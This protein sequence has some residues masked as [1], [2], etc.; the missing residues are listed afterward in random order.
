MSRMSLP[1]VAEVL[2][3]CA[4]LANGNNWQ[5][6][7]HFSRSFHPGQPRG[8]RW[9][10]AQLQQQ[11][12]KAALQLWQDIVETLR[13]KA[14][15]PAR[16]RHAT[17]QKFYSIFLNEES[18]I[19]AALHRF[20]AELP[21]GYGHAAAK[22]VHQEVVNVAATEANRSS[23]EPSMTL[24]FSFCGRAVSLSSVKAS[25]TIKRLKQELHDQGKLS[26]SEWSLVQVILNGKAI[27]DATVLNTLLLD[28]ATTIHLIRGSFTH[29][30]EVAASSRSVQQTMRR[31]FTRAQAETM[32]ASSAD[33]SD[34]QRN[35]PGLSD[36]EYSAQQRHIYKKYQDRIKLAGFR[37]GVVGYMKAAGLRQD[38]IT[39]TDVCRDK[40]K[41]IIRFKLTPYGDKEHRYIV[42]QS[43]IDQLYHGCA[44]G[45][46]KER[47]LANPAE[48][49]EAYLDLL[50][51]AAV[52]DSV[53]CTM[54]RGDALLIHGKSYKVNVIN[55]WL[56]FTK[57]G[58]NPILS[59]NYKVNG[60]QVP[61]R[62]EL[63]LA[64]E[65]GL[66]R[67]MTEQAYQEEVPARGTASAYRKCGVKCKFGLRAI[68]AKLMQHIVAQDRQLDYADAH[69]MSARGRV[70]MAS[71]T[72]LVTARSGAGHGAG[73]GA[74][75]SAG[76]Q[77]DEVTLCVRLL[78]GQQMSMTMTNEKTIADIKRTMI[79]K[80][81]SPDYLKQHYDD[82]MQMKLIYAGCV[83]D[84]ALPVSV[85]DTD[86]TVLNCTIP[87]EYAAHILTADQVHTKSA[88]L[89]R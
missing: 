55:W 68:S 43:S 34:L 79:N 44:S 48:K 77:Q 24:C 41:Y 16:R 28:G 27:A 37:E 67:Y 45:D 26:A 61:R 85:I 4:E 32:A 21:G 54:L 39:V 22:G 58:E 2:S 87:R 81:F 42:D 82:L 18:D 33:L 51:T 3:A 80:Y 76:V 59:I 47:T 60:G 72:R 15:H 29:A 75:V 19:L 40:A 52:K 1:V 11:Q 46:N 63:E 64:D 71:A 6:W 78:T 86:A 36:D 66:H 84:D 56:S 38:Q 69:K 53:L 62:F 73:I 14:L 50:V 10:S 13:Y 65:G 12:P 25:W 8:I 74:G 83:I 88:E 89:R 23:A 35:R 17:T 5:V 7:S 20:N 30:G 49:A 31:A 70:T 57:A 9:L